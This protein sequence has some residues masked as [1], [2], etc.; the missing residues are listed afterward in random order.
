M[1]GPKAPPISIKAEGPSKMDPTFLPTPLMP[2]GLHLN[3]VCG[4][5]CACK[6]IIDEPPLVPAIT[7]TAF[8]ADFVFMHPLSMLVSPLHVP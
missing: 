1:A 8:C 6:H 7:Y 4:A 3:K 2:D 5:S